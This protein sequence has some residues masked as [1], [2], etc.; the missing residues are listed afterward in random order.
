MWLP[1]TSC[2]KLCISYGTLVTDKLSR[3]WNW[4]LDWADVTKAPIWDSTDGFGGDGDPS[5]GSELLKGHCVVDGP[6][7]MLEVLYLD[8]QDS[9][10]C[11]SRGFASGDLLAQQSEKI[12]PESIEKI[13]LKRDYADFNLGLEMAGHNAIPRSIRGDF[14]MFTAPYGL[15]VSMSLTSHRCLTIFADP[16]FYLHHTQLDR[17][18]AMWQQ[19]DLENIKSQYS[20]V[21][22]NGSDQRASLDDVLTFGGLAS[23]VKVSDIIDTRSG[24]LC[25]SY[26]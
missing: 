1:R 18:W 21:A 19:I 11:L 2:V 20:G 4:L 5:K 3:Y 9:R 16:V 22:S 6:F 25:Y 17:L 8:R 26:V 24:I 15:Y 7:A 23:D 14:S 12:R 10:H 13:L